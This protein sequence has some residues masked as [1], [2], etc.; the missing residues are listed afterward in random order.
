M[1][2]RYQSKIATDLL[3]TRNNLQ[4]KRK[5]VLLALRQNTGFNDGMYELP[6]G[7]VDLGED[8]INTM[9]REAKEELC[10]TLE[11]KDLK[12]KFVFHDY[13]VNYLKFIISAT[14]YTGELK[15]GE[16]EKCKEIKWF[17][18]DELPENMDIRNKNILK[19]IGRNVFYDNSEFIMI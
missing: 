16:P 10:I 3:L 12:I 9:I 11:R 5:E 8:L 6:G 1:N 7:H 18:L 4:S 2:E 13:R 14:K 15:V 19:E 17:N